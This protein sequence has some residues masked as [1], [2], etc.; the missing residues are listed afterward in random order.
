MDIKRWT[1]QD[2]VQALRLLG[3]TQSRLARELG[4]SPSTVSYGI[5]TGCS[6]AIRLHVARLLGERQQDLWP[7]RFP[8][9]WRDG[10]AGP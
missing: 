4:V 2:I 8:P 10:H 6:Q 5:K 3:W 7:S 9:Q 1:Y